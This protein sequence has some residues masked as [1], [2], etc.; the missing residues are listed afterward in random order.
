MIRLGLVGVGPRP[1][2]FFHLLRCG[3]ASDLAARAMFWL[4]VPHVI[5]AGYVLWHS[6]FCAWFVG[7]L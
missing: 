5:V 7:G 1:A 3:Q 2:L 4:A 6:V